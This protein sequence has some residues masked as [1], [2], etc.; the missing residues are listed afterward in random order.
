VLLGQVGHVSTPVAVPRFT[1]IVVHGQ[2]Y[3]VI[4][5]RVRVWREGTL[6]GREKEAR[7]DADATTPRESLPPHCQHIKHSFSL[8]RLPLSVSLGLSTQSLSKHTAEQVRHP[9]I[10]IEYSIPTR[11]PNEKKNT[12]RQAAKTANT[13]KHTE[14]QAA[15]APTHPDDTQPDIV[16]AGKHGNARDNHQRRRYTSCAGSRDRR[17]K[18]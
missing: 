14:R 18:S 17:A 7:S 10:F 9:S 2:T 5:V 16:N 8:S 12:E 15:R 11:T 1:S 4:R 13:I 6:R 3:T